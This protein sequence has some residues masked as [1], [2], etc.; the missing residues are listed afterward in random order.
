MHALFCCSQLQHHRR[1]ITLA[2][3]RISLRIHAVMASAQNVQAEELYTTTTLDFTSGTISVSQ[4]P[5]GAAP[6]AS[7]TRA[8]RS[9]IKALTRGC[10]I[11]VG[12]SM[13]IWLLLG[14]AVVEVMCGITALLWGTR[15]RKEPPV[16]LTQLSYAGRI[17][18]PLSGVSVTRGSASALTLTNDPPESNPALNE[19][20]WLTKYRGGLWVSRGVQLIADDNNQFVRCIVQQCI[21]GTSYAK[22]LVVQHIIKICNPMLPLHHQLQPFVSSMQSLS[23]RNVSYA[24]T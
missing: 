10:V 3:Q 21:Q 11:A 24:V 8:M 6:Q 17:T 5:H 18:T 9:A 2:A 16:T 23:L 14:V 1:A 13:A 15:Q 19:P 12:L 4:P 20:S 22:P 7:T